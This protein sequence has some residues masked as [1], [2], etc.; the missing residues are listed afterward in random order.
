M[1]GRGI[2]TSTT[3]AVMVAVIVMD[4]GSDELIF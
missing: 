2:S 1:E 4:G 3:I